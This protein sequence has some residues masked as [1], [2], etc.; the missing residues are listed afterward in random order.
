MVWDVPSMGCSS[1]SAEGPHDP[2]T[3]PMRSHS[4]SSVIPIAGGFGKSGCGSRPRV[5]VAGR[6]MSSLH[7]CDLHSDTLGQVPPPKDVL[8]P[9]WPIPC[10]ISCIPVSPCPHL[11]LRDMLS[12]SLSHPLSLLPVSLS[13]Q[14]SGWASNNTIPVSHPPSWPRDT[15]GTRL[16]HPTSHVS[17]PCSLSWPRDILCGNLYHPTS[18]VPLTALSQLAKGYT[19]YQIVP[20]HIPRP[21]SMSPELAKGHIVYQPVPSYFL[22]PIFLSSQHAK[23]HIGYQTVPSHVPVP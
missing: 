5:K 6:V 11:W 10:P 21:I 2:R 14:E 22:C 17:L 12:T 1:L 13:G 18:Y 8:V 15:L 23:G 3:S 20:S 16:S 19:R 7:G 9:N 4:T